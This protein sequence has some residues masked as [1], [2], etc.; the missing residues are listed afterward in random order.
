MK[1][2]ILDRGSN[3]STKPSVL[4]YDTG[5]A[6]PLL[7]SHYQPKII[8]AK[9]EKKLTPFQQYRKE[10]EAYKC[11]KQEYSE[12]YTQKKKNETQLL[13]T[14][15][16]QKNIPKLVKSMKK[17]LRKYMSYKDKS[18]SIKKKITANQLTI[19]NLIKEHK[20]NQTLIP[21]L[22]KS[23]PILQTKITFY[24]EKLN[25]KINE[26]CRLMNL[27]PRESWTDSWYDGISE[28]QY[29]KELINE[30]NIQLTPQ[31]N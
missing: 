13:N 21:N 17:T 2:G 22:E 24:K 27:V 23:I 30:L 19:K 28:E 5:T 14:I 6:N 9:P 11:M 10:N 26:C 7:Q 16:K 29:N 3:P 31:Y 12:L 4:S 1:F 25:S 20:T 8:K 18:N 15:R